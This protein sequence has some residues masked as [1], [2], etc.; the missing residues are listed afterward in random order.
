MVAGDLVNTASRLQSAAPPGTVLVGEATQRATL[1]R[2]RVRAGRRAAAQG[3]GGAGPGL[4]RA[5]R[6][7]ASVGG[8]GRGDRLE[9]PFV[10]RDDGAA[11]AQ[12]PVPRDRRARSASGSCRSPGQAGIG[13]SRLAW[14]FQKYVDGVVEDVCWH[15]GRSPA[16]R[17]GHHVLGA[18]ARWSAARAQ[19]AR[20]GRPGDDARR[21]SP[22]SVAR[23]FPTRRERRRI[24]PRPPG[25]ARRRATRRPAAPSELFGAWRTFFE[26]IADAGPRRRWSSRTSTGP[27]RGLLDFIDHMLE[28]SRNVPILI[29]TLA[30]PGAPRAAARTGAP[31]SRNFL[32]LDLEPLDEAPMRELL[33]GL[34][35]G[36]PERGRPVDRRA[37]RGH[38]A[39]R[40]RDDPDA[41]RRRP[42][43]RARGRRVRAGR[44]ARRAG[45]ARTRSTR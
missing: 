11:P 36:L 6:R 5:P 44:R 34:V 35:P 12:G 14:E 39:V 4:A 18:R 28:W 1:G 21:R 3:Q 15:E 45:R 26:R 17:R 32:A 23:T 27:T 16:V 8:R 10:G 41:R 9:A 19:L 20:D 42:P 25:A 7:R 37:R 30:R 13:K 29:V 40:G 2:D 24:E 33:A 38:P 43:A 31:G 22:R